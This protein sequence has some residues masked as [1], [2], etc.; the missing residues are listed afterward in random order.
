MVLTVL[1]PYT[2]S[3]FLEIR[4]DFRKGLHTVYDL[5]PIWR[6]EIEVIIKLKSNILDGI[7]PAHSDE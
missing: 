6:V 2:T 7:N 1:M 4:F 5:G 3:S